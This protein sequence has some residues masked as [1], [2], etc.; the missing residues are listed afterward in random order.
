MRFHMK[1]IFSRNTLLPG[2]GALGRIS[3]AGLTLS[4]L[5]AA[6]KDAVRVV[7]SDIAVP[8]RMMLNGNE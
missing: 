7:I 4:S 3:D 8:I 6:L 2:L 1:V 5:Y